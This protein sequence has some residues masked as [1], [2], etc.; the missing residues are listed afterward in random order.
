MLVIDA[1]AIVDLLLDRQSRGLIARHLAEHDHDLHAPHLIDI[2][3]LNVMRRQVARGLIA[4]SRADEAVTDLLDL[5]VERY[6]HR[7]LGR[8]IWALRE[9][10]SAYDASYLALAEALAPSGAALLTTDVRFA[11]AVREHSDVE[12]LLAA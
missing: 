4:D 8:R 9:N 3:V 1:S 2:E 12:V 7:V 5:W 10:F 11:R 6:P